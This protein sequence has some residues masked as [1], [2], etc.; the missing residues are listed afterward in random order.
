MAIDW[1]KEQPLLCSLYISDYRPLS[2]NNVA[3]YSD[4]SAFVSHEMVSNAI[5]KRMWRSLTSSQKYFNKWKVKINADKSHSTIF[6]F[7]KALKRIHCLSKRMVFFH[8]FDK[9]SGHNTWSETFIK[10][11]LK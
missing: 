6:P 8:R 2:G 5:V 1:M 9:I 7:K 3:L 10:R 4:D 11:S